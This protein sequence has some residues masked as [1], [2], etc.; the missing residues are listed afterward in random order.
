MVP[1]S[2]LSRHLTFFLACSVAC[3]GCVLSTQY[4]IPPAKRVEYVDATH[5]VDV[6]SVPEGAVVRRE[7][8]APAATPARVK[9]PYRIERR[10]SV[11]RFKLFIAA[12]AVSFGLFIFALDRA[13]DRNLDG[14]T[15]DTFAPWK[16]DGLLLYLAAADACSAA[17]LINVNYQRRE[18]WR[19]FATERPL[20]VTEQLMIDWPGWASVRTRVDVPAQ[21]YLTI[22]R[23]SLGTFDEALIR[24]HR[25][26]TVAPTTKGLIELAGAYDRL[27]GQTGSADHARRA[28]ELY[29][30]YAAAPD[31]DPGKLAAARDRAAA[32][33]ARGGKP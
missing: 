21:P 13:I 24:W 16:P 27:A 32:L 30:Q 5:T 22:R 1:L 4:L 33:R 23:P 14:S 6:R 29:E 10:G 31:A 2:A 3:S 28:V 25:T 20:P 17:F 12:A 11:P 9:I 15:A 8:Q 26:T 18:T 19:N 7:G